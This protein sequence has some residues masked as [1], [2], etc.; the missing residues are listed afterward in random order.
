[1]NIYREGRHR[2]ARGAYGCHLKIGQ[3]LALPR[4]LPALSSSPLIPPGLFRA[5]FNQPCKPS[6][7]S[8]NTRPTPSSVRP[9]SENYR[10]DDRVEHGGRTLLPAINRRLPSVARS[11]RCAWSFYVLTGPFPCMLA[12][13]LSTSDIPSRDCH[14]LLSLPPNHGSDDLPQRGTCQGCP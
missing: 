13:P 4:P 9:S 12:F 14:G 1:M 7:G 8:L 6:A 11:P 3:F 5:I 10:C 2:D